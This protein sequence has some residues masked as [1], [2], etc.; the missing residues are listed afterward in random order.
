MPDD[1]ATLESQGFPPIDLV[2]VNLYPFEATIARPDATFADARS[3]T[4]TS[5]GPTLIRAAAKNH[6]HVAVLT[7]PSQYDV[8]D[9]ALRDHGG[10]TL[11][12]SA[13]LALAAFRATGVI[14]PGD[15]RL[16]GPGH[17]RA[18]RDSRPVS[19]RISTFAS[20]CGS[21]SATARTPT[22][23]RRSTS[24]RTP[25]GPNLATAKLRHG[26]EL[27]YN[28]L[29]DLDSALRLVRQFAEPAACILK[30]NNPCGAAI[31]GEPARRSSAPTRATRSVPSAAS[32]V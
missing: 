7:S 11:E 32:S 22:S 26:K 25:R 1:L 18:G 12:R 15:R 31:A 6:A 4:S 24:S 16:P 28:N 2:V 9:R 29:L 30:H 21:H 27:S 14:R 13:P 17:R 3:R 8:L 23:R 19:R 10:T 20:T 5:A